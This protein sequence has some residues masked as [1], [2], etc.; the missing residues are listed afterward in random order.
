MK[1]VIVLAFAFIIQICIIMA[2]QVSIVMA[3]EQPVKG[4]R[5]SSG[6]LTTAWTKVTG[7]GITGSVTFKSITLINLGDTLKYTTNATDT[8]S[9][10]YAKWGTILPS[11]I[12]DKLKSVIGD[13][14]F[15]K[16]VSANGKYILTASVR[17]SIQGQDGGQSVY[18]PSVTATVNG[19]SSVHD[20]T[21]FSDTAYITINQWKGAAALT[22]TSGYIVD[23][24]QNV[25]GSFFSLTAARANGM[26]GYI[27]AI[28]M[29][30][31]TA[32]T[33]GATFDILIFRDTVGFGAAL[34]ANNTQWITSFDMGKF[35]VGHEYVTLT[36]YGTTGGARGYTQTMIPFKCR[37]DKRSLFFLIIANGA[38][39]PA[40]N[41]HFRVRFFFERN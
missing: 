7:L 26:G 3:Q 38:Y 21:T 41:A 36:A 8:L 9:A 10:S 6:V 30:A 14:I 37:A 2:Q 19:I 39:K 33:T 12:D 28:D 31:D 25:G 20:S 1:K 29:G 23:T 18:N 16:S 11:L 34:Q 22:Y 35:Y 40:Y 4:E 13:S 32:N 24:N 27:T 17:N 15:L 5:N